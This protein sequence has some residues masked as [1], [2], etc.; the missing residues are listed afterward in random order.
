MRQKIRQC[1]VDEAEPN[2]LSAEQKS[3]MLASRRLEEFM[4]TAILAL[5]AVGAVS[6]ITAAPAQARPVYPI[7]LQTLYGDNDCTY[8]SFQQCMATGSGLGQSCIANPALPYE[9]S[10]VYADEPPPPQRQ[11]RPRRNY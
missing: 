8:S 11:P 10:P 6:A 4:R 2:R 7:C 9:A 1:S 5:M 3:R